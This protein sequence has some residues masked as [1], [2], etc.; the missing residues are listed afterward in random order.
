M[1]AVSTFVLFLCQNTGELRS[2]RRRRRWWVVV[3]EAF[4][5]AHARADCE[6][7]LIWWQDD[8]ERRRRPT[9]VFSC[10]R[11]RGYC[12]WFCSE[13][14]YVILVIVVKKSNNRDFSFVFVMFVSSVSRLFGFLV[15]AA[16]RVWHLF[17]FWRDDTPI[18][19][20]D[21]Y[22]VSLC[23]KSY[24]ANPSFPTTMEQGRST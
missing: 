20:S 21:K 9:K 24:F 8:V 23:F 22:D 19:H 3:G 1:L 10:G 5:T 2:R 16:R 18:C 6:S 14:E 17:G 7:L 13:C 4:V 11:C 15:L 12:C